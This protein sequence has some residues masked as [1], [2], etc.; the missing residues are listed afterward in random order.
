MSRTD[1]DSFHCRKC[2]NCCKIPGIVR[3]RGN[4][5]K[6][7]AAS[8]SMAEE[9]FIEAYTG[10]SPDRLSLSLKDRE[11]GAC[12]M[13]GDDNL[14]MVNEAKPSQCKDFPYRWR[15]ASSFEYCEGLKGVQNA[16]CDIIATGSDEDIDSKT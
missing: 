2:G 5:V 3:L 8:L 1:I 12:I 16:R 4:D 15:N 6:A 9:E 14:C 7:M 13:L 11:D 10:I